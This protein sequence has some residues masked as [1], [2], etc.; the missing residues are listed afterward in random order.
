MQ[1]NKL[2][3]FWILGTATGACVLS[4]GFTPPCFNF[5]VVPQNTSLAGAGFVVTIADVSGLTYNGTTTG[6]NISGTGVIRPLVTSAS[7][8]YASLTPIL[9]TAPMKGR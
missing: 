3:Q 5:P 9:T 8:T 2:V 6:A 7:G 4:T 1:A